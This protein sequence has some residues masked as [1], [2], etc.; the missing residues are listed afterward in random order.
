MSV[1]FP[2]NELGMDGPGDR[3][4]I[5]R[6]YAVRLK[7]CRPEDD[8]EGFARL[9]Q[10]YEI[11]QAWATDQDGQP[12]A[13]VFVAA[14]PEGDDRPP[15]P[16]AS[17]APSEMEP[18]P[19]TLARRDNDDPQ[20]LAQALLALEPAA[21]ARE[22]VESPALWK[23]EVKDRLSA[24]LARCV[25][26]APGA[27]SSETVAILAASFH[28]D[29]VAECR[30]LAQLH[31]PVD[32]LQQIL[33]AAQLR[34]VVDEGGPD[35]P[36][37]AQNLLR[38]GAGPKAWAYALRWKGAANVAA[39]LSQFPPPVARLVFGD[40]VIR[41]WNLVG[42]D[43][44]VLALHMLRLNLILLGLV[45]W[46]RSP[47]YPEVSMGDFLRAL[48]APAKIMNALILSIASFKLSVI[49]GFQPISQPVPLGWSRRWRLAAIAVLIAVMAVMAAFTPLI[50]LTGLSLAI[51]GLVCVTMLKFTSS[52]IW[53]VSTLAFIGAGLR[54]LQEL[55]LFR[56][57]VERILSFDGFWF[58]LMLAALLM[59]VAEMVVREADAVLRWLPPRMSSGIPATAVLLVIWL[60]AQW[61]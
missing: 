51:A 44:G 26:A 37:L 27:V 12:I 30:R 31:I 52:L 58:G 32:V 8:A 17:P 11:A 41:F 33:Q 60:F 21:L 35:V 48:G 2:W 43:G 56:P 14:S 19:W 40:N 54:G 22:L 53:G 45:L 38:W 13:P 59:V 4:A 29:D 10:A 7:S 16:P 3:R 47:G 20:A 39:Y 34:R 46:V 24:I 9:R 1:D 50:V 49:Y 42:C 61:F 23:L 57:V 25:I 28:W 15:A 5:K 55:S 36:P 6:A 18:E